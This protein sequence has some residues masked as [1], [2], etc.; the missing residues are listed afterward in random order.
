ML[1]RLL[2]F[3]IV[4]K[5]RDPE[6]GPNPTRLM[7][8][9]QGHKRDHLCPMKRALPIISYLQGPLSEADG[10]RTRN[11]RIDSPHIP[12]ADTHTADC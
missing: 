1:N 6:I 12:D 9:H 8:D 10:T 2:G 11:H 7:R 4:S 5:R 3:W